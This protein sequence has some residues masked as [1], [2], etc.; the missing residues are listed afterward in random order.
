MSYID[1]PF[2]RRLV[3]LALEEDLALGDVT[4]AITVPETERSKASII[5]REELLV[6]GLD[7]VDVVISEGRF[8]ATFTRSVSDG[9]MAKAGDVLGELSGASRHLLALERTVL[10]FLQRMSGVA[11]HTRRFV[12]KADGLKVLDTRK[13][14]PG[15][16]VLDKYATRIGGARNHRLSLGDM[17]LVKN[18]HIDAHPGGIR[19]ALGEIVAK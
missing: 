1:S 12:S 6:C 14:M 18:N 4:A 19:G 10:N 13:T 3:A 11:T 17:I 2:V 8:D 16:R 9:V 5:A 7:L 15:F